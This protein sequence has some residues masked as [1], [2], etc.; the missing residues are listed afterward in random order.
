MRAFIH[1]TI[2]IIKLIKRPASMS[3]IQREF[4]LNTPEAD[5]LL[6]QY[7]TNKLSG[8]LKKLLVYYNGKEVAQVETHKQIREGVTFRSPHKQQISVSVSRNKLWGQDVVKVLVDGVRLER[9]E[10][11]LKDIV[12]SGAWALIGIGSISA[13]IGF[14]SS[15]LEI[16]ELQRIGIDWVSAIG[17]I[18]YIVLGCVIMTYNWFGYY[19]LLFSILLFVFDSIYM[20]VNTVNAGGSVGAGVGIKVM[21][22]I[23]LLRALPASWKLARHTNLEHDPVVSPNQLLDIRRY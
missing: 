8:K 2:N 14:A 19:A 10:S 11:E 16:A 4:I 22:L 12:E 23:L 13:L 3:I 6:I 1:Y 21:I 15:A 9:S 5:S 18:L 17:S 7:S 20:A